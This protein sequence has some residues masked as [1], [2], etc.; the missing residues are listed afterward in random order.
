MITLAYQFNTLQQEGQEML[1]AQLE[2]YGFHGFEEQEN[3]L[4][5]YVN[6]KDLVENEFHVFISQNNI[7]YTKSIIEDKNWNEKL[8][9]N[10]LERIRNNVHSLA[11]QSPS[12]E[13]FFVSKIDAEEIRKHMI[14]SMLHQFSVFCHLKIHSKKQQ[15]PGTR[16]KKSNPRYPTVK[17]SMKLNC[18][19]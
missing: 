19:V 2:L 5:A 14:K 7:I 16:L 8:D 12:G 11:S 9:N 3:S 10:S 4:L 1:I 6:E 15:Y 17:S 18:S 13:R